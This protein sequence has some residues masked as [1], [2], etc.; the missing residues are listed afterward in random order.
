MIHSM[1][2]EV[3]NEVQ[4]KMISNNLRLQQS[5]KAHFNAPQPFAF[6][7]FSFLFLTR[8]LIV[9][10]KCLVYSP[11]RRD[12]KFLGVGGGPQRPKIV[13]KCMELN[14]KFH[15]RVSSPSVGGGM[16]NKIRYR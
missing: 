2:V 6:V 4:V 7:L 8:C 14:W 11:Y 9:S 10:L 15:S 3:Q 12:W 13:R 16:D 1:S 5:F